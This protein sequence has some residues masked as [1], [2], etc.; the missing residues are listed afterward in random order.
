MQT[1]DQMGHSNVGPSI[2][3]HQFFNTDIAIFEKSLMI[4]L[5]SIYCSATYWFV[6]LKIAE[7]ELWYHASTSEKG[8]FWAL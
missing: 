2:S 7:V 3:C 8:L 6:Y 1:Y 5:I 4:L